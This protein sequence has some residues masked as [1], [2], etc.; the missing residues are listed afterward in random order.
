MNDGQASVVSMCQLSLPGF[1]GSA[2]A[3]LTLVAQH[4]LSAN[5][6]P[7]ADVTRQFLV[8]MTE[9]QHLNLHL[10]G[11]LMAASA[12]LMMMKSSQLLIQPDDGEDEEVAG[13]SAFDPSV[14]RQF[15]GAIDSLSS[16][17]GQE[18]FL[19]FAPPVEIERRSE[20]RSPHLLVRAWSEMAG[21]ATHSERRVHVPSFVRLEAAVSG[22]IRAL[23]AG[24]KLLFRHVIRDSNQDDTVVHFM[25][26]LELVRQGRVRVEQDG[27]F[28]DITMH[29]IAEHAESSSRLG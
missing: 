22:L 26:M 4:K 13:A 7:V 8:H 21:R 9:T 17:E 24:T 28:T 11:E 12:R 5:E 2:D 16:S 29:W 25:A 14:R 3:F 20:P 27:L 18:S 6:V 23:R 1:E 15:V 19:P 10:A